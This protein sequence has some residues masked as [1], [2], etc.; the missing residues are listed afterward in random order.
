VAASKAAAIQQGQ[1][2]TTKLCSG[3][4][5]VLKNPV[6]WGHRPQK[7][8]HFQVTE[9]LKNKIRFVRF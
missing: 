2:V 1:A 3:T 8:P 9:P 4:A 5:Y 7:T 6:F